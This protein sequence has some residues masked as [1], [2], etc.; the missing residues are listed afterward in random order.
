MKEKEY[1]V[2]MCRIKN[3]SFVPSAKWADT[4]WFILYRWV[5]SIID[6]APNLS[7]AEHWNISMALV[8]CH[9]ASLTELCFFIPDLELDLVTVTSELVLCALGA[10]YLSPHGSVACNLLRSTHHKKYAWYLP[11][12]VKTVRKTQI[13]LHP[14]FSQSGSFPTCWPADFP[15]S[16]APTAVSTHLGCSENLQ[17]CAAEL[18][19][20][21][22]MIIS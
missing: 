11:D 17:S 20:Y 10:S 1:K 9:E 13:D 6:S 3:Q 14:A 15:Q 7:D 18:R 22:H 12:E 4:V 21:G 16:L 8:T 5:V 2:S 19:L